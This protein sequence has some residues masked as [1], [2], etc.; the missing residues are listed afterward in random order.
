MWNTEQLC[1]AMWLYEYC[2]EWQISCR[3]KPWK[4]FFVYNSKQSLLTLTSMMTR[5]ILKL[6]NA[7]ILLCKN[8]SSDRLIRF[9][10]MSSDIAA[11]AWYLNY[12]MLML[13][14]NFFLFFTNKSLVGLQTACSPPLSPPWLSTQ[15]DIFQGKYIV[16]HS[17]F[18]ITKH[19]VKKRDRYQNIHK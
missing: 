15:A 12:D 6:L 7:A 1:L 2:D 14:G 8:I 5:L 11:Y 19:Y 3:R 9:A 16:S 18:F 13:S 10:Q 17:P 4:H